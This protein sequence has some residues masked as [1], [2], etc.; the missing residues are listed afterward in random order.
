MQLVLPEA[1]TLTLSLLRTAL[2]QKHAPIADT[3]LLIQP[4]LVAI[5]RCVGDPQLAM[6]QVFLLVSVVAESVTRASTPKHRTAHL[7]H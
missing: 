4:L 2:E 3:S 7:T 1:D 5:Q 6:R